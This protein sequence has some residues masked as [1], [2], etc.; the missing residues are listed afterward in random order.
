MY[1]RSNILFC[2]GTH[3]SPTKFLEPGT[4]FLTVLQNRS[5]FH[6][7]HESHRNFLQV[8]PS[9]PCN[10]AVKDNKMIFADM[11]TSAL[12][13]LDGELVDLILHYDLDS[14][15]FNLL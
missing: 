3:E 4:I 2:I 11:T 8:A 10:H 13:Q 7:H 14:N 5:S 15:D 1:I 6:N 12:I 9:M